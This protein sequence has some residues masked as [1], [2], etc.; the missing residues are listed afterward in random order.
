MIRSILGV[1][2]SLAWGIGT[3]ALAAGHQTVE[4]MTHELHNGFPTY[5]GAPGFE[6]EQAF[7]FATH[8][9]NLNNLSI[10]EHTG[11]HIDAPLHFSAD[12]NSVAEIAIV[13]LPDSGQAVAGAT[14]VVPLETLLTEQLVMRVDGGQERLLTSSFLDEGPTWSPNGR[15]IMFARETQGAGGSSSLYSVDISGRNLRP[16]RTPEGGSDPS[17]SPLQQ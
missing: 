5:F 15:V 6:A 14:I 1:T 7:N 2:L 12:G 4:D 17:W 9:F 8:G 13:S 10:N 16:V 11:T 3:P